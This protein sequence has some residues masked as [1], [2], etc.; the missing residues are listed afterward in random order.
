MTRTSFNELSAGEAFFLD[1]V[2]YVKLKDTE[3][4]NCIDAEFLTY[5]G[6]KVAKDY[7]RY[8]AEGVKVTTM[9]DA[10]ASVE[11]VSKVNR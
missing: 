10:V 3:R 5:K 8:V 7:L 6:D 9:R 4:F 2:L 1:C 11:D